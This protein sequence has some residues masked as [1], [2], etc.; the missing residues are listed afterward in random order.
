MLFYLLTFVLGFVLD[1]ANQD[2]K[3]I[4]NIRK[5][6]VVWLYVFLC[7]G[8]MT[9][10]DWRGYEITYETIHTIQFFFH[11]EIGFYSLFRLL[12]VFISDYW[13]AVG[14]LKCLYFYTLLRVLKKLTPYW[15]SV[16]SLLMTGSL[17]FIL[18]DNPL[19]FMVA[20]TIVNIAIEFVLDKKYLVSAALVVASFF[21]HNTCIFFIVIIPLS[22]FADKLS[23]V[24][25]LVL[26]II[27]LGVVF[28]SSN[29]AI[30]ETIRTSV[31]GQVILLSEG[32]K[33][34]S[35][36]M[37]ESNKSFFSIG[38]I[39]GIIFFFLV[40]FSRDKVIGNYKNGEFV[41]GMALIYMFFA[42]VLIMIPTGFRLNI[43]FDTFYMLYIVYLIRSKCF[44][45]WIFIAYFCI[46]FPRH[47]WTSYVYVP[48]SNSIPYILSKHKPYNERSTYNF[49]AYYERTGKAW[50]KE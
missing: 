2:N 26:A 27:F 19:R 21:F 16:V 10:S 15:L 14:L 24:N 33:D 37:V 11:R 30:I 47:L 44:Y 34:Y 41:Y 4:I 31:V 48:Y 13:L 35:S 42:R 49:N 39:I 18:I 40:L 8:Y 9:G 20:L 46:A 22:L 25:R 29:V 5:I 23:N 50:D 28:L 3:T 36:Y 32:M 12:R 43:P 45:K 38:N 1:F 17:I 6:F 7:F